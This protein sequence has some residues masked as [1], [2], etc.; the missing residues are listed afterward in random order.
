M[1]ADDAACNSRNHF[2][3][4]V[5]ANRGHALDL[6]GENI[7]VDYRGY[8]VTVQNF[9]RLLTGMPH[10]SSPA[11]SHY[12]ETVR[13]QPV[14][15]ACMNRS[16]RARRAKVKAPAYGRPVEHICLYDRSWR[17]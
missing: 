6:Y 2:P 8:E 17:R 13:Q 4:C 3:G 11:F 16:S 1:L 15:G 5:F 7:E 14:L 10:L 12:D 9:L